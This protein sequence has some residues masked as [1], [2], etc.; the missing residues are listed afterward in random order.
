[1]RDAG[2]PLSR[3]ARRLRSST[4]PRTAPT[5]GRRTP[6]RSCETNVARHR[7][8]ARR[9]RGT[10]RAS[11]TPARRRSTG[12][13]DA[14][15]RRG[16]AARAEQRL[17]RR[18]R[19]RRPTATPRAARRRRRTLRLYSVY[20][21]WEEPNRLVPTLLGARA[22][23]ASCRRSSSPRGRARLRL[24]RRRLR[25]VRAGAPSAPSPAR[26]YNVGTGRQT[27]HRRGRRGCARRLAG[28]E[29]EPQWGSMPDR[30]WDTDTWVANPARIRAELGWEPRI[31]LEE[32]LRAHA[33]V[34]QDGGAA[35][36]IRIARVAIGPRRSG[37]SATTPRP[38]FSNRPSSSACGRMC[39]PRSC[40][41]NHRPR[42]FC[43]SATG[44]KRDDAPPARARPAASRTATEVSSEQVVQEVDHQGQVEPLV[45]ARE[46]D[47]VEALERRRALPRRRARGRRT[48]QLTS[49]PR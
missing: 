47:R 6:R 40:S 17:R 42:R 48:A 32:G 22:R 12:C 45:L 2:R 46:V 25:G 39:S 19:R 33:R 14:R 5:R 3:G 26:V 23:R 4:S 16:R 1:M 8:P 30:G 9:L 13:K 38:A 49:T 7:A 37:S 35:G 10:A 36:T 31:G 41:M 21:P 18:A 34:A 29:A 24:R 44:S 20:G 27:T 43:C 28:V 11:C 15:A